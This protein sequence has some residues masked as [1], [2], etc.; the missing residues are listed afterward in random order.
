MNLKKILPYIYILFAT[1][2]MAQDL[3]YQPYRLISH[4]EFAPLR[5]YLNASFDVGQNP[6]F[7]HQ[8]NYWSNHKKVWS[9]IK[10]PNRSIKND[11]GYGEFFSK[12]FFG[13][14][15]LP[16]YSLHL[17]GGGY[18]Y[19]QLY[20]WF[21]ERNYEY[22]WAWALITSYAGHMGNESYEA[23]NPKIKSHDHI[24]DLLFFDI[25][26]KFL[27]MNDTFARFVV[28]ELGFSGWH[29]QP[30]Y[31]YNDREIRN[32]GLNYIARPKCLSYAGFTPFVF[33]GM[34][35]LGG[36]SYQFKNEEYVTGAFGV[37]VTEPFEKKWFYSGLLAYDIKGEPRAILNINGTEAMR[38][39]LLIYP[40][41]FSFYPKYQLGLTTFL[42]REGGV[43]AGVQLNLPLGVS[44]S[45]K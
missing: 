38:V 45:W 33:M 25:A 18:D 29:Y 39:R 3:V 10:N 8:D 26:G 13:E 22:A 17:L 35:V 36:L 41:V 21:K 14:N 19:R 5:H 30:L 20:H 6:Y 32:S 11:G 37:A 16:N 2:V 12:E 27:M 7:F 44:G 15:A 34:Q 28:D 24:A 23:S 43:G 1:S 4:D 9:R 40:S 42:A 31:Y